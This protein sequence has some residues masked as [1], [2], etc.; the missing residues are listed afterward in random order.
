M[1]KIPD[2]ST[3][4]QKMQI[5]HRTQM[6]APTSETG[7][8]RIS[9][10]HFCAGADVVGGVVCGTIAPIL[11][12]MRG[13]PIERVRSYCR[14]MRWELLTQGVDREGHHV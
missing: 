7:L 9:A 13:W 11:R 1:V 12:Y 6:S 8:L 2:T 14:S 4:L 5:T 10:P 3:S